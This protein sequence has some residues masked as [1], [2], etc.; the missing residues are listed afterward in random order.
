M[1]LAAGFGSR[2]MPLTRDLPKCLV[3]VG[4]VSI[5]DRMI[6]RLEAA[7][8]HELVVVAG[9]AEAALRA[10]LEGANSAAA[11]RAVVVTNPRYR[12]WGNFYSLLVAEDAI[13]DH[14]F[15]KLD[16]DVLLDSKVLPRLVA[17]S[18]PAVLVVD[19][20][21][22]VGDEE[23]KAAIDHHG[24][25]VALNKRMAA[26]SALGESIG[27][28]RIDRSAKPQ[29]F[30]ALRQLIETGETAE[31]YERAYERLMEDEI[32]FSWI[33][34]SDCEWCEVDCP[35]DLP[36]AEQCLARMG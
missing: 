6:E 26:E 1:I 36:L 22:P 34:I 3:A 10:H 28:E 16:A 15:I 2:L 33:D 24:R 11:R 17:A 27:V 5:L 30:K 8:V 9:H 18:G 31:Y 12:D 14:G 23:M 29:V 35:E 13:G 7:G 25:V 20:K 21:N 19:R 32:A 4:G